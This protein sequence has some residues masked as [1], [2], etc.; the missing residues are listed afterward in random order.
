M[1][2]HEGQTFHDESL[3]PYGLGRR[4]IKNYYQNECEVLIC[5]GMPEGIGKSG[6]VNHGLADATG[7]LACHDKDK[8]Q[9]MYKKNSDR[10]ADAP[11]WEADYEAAKKLIM[12]E[13]STVV[14]WLMQ[15]LVNGDRVPMWHWDDGGTWLNSMEYN[16]DFVKAFMQFLPLARSVCGLVVIS[17]PVEEWCLKK[18]HTSTGVIHAPV[19]KMGG[20]KHIW[21][22]RSCKPYRKVR[23]PMCVRY[24]PQ[25]QWEDRFSAIMP[26][27]FYKWYKPQRDHYTKIAVA[28]MH[29]S[30]QKKKASGKD[31]FIDEE[32]LAQVEATVTKTADK[33]ME[34]K[35]VIAQHSV[36]A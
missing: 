25:Y 35:E 30:L 34:F 36:I 13:P 10:P 32:I 27:S 26:D 29:L 3:R 24:F 5:T 21:R 16:D 15:M 19:I 28:K 7:F 20:D 22:P 31:V 14:D 23:N 18:L 6:Y 1:Y 2:E 4:A 17:S 9:W 12:Y 11:I 8:L 33:L